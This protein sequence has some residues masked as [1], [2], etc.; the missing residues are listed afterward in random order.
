MVSVQPN[1]KLR[2]GERTMTIWAGEIFGKTISGINE[3]AEP[4]QRGQ[5]GTT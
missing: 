3:I 2:V 5:N 4:Q 1:A